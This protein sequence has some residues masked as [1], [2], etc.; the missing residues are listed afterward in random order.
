MEQSS[1]FSNNTDNA[2]ALV[3]EEPTLEQ[4]NT[5]KQQLESRCTKQ[6]LLKYAEALLP[7]L[8]QYPAIKRATRNGRVVN[9]TEVNA[10]LKSNS[11]KSTI[12][13]GVALIL[14]NDQNLKAYID[15]M[16]NELHE[17][18][19]ILLF[20]IFLTHTEA[21]LILK[22][23][24]DLLSQ[25][26]SNYYSGGGV[27]WKKRE[28]GFFTTAN[29]RASEKSKYGYRDYETFI[30][31]KK[32]IRDLFMPHFFPEACDSEASLNEL[33][34]GQWQTVNFEIE[35]Q[36]QYQLFAGLM[37]QD[38][39]PVKKKGI[40]ITDMKRAMKK[41]ALTEFF[42]D[43]QNEY[44]QNLHAYGYLQLLGLNSTYFIKKG[45][46]TTP[47]EQVVRTLIDNFSKLDYFVAGILYPHIKGLT[48]QMTEYGRETKLCLNML[49]CLRE[50][51]ERWLSIRDIYL[52]ICY[53]DSQENTSRYVA[54][55]FNPNDE[56]YTT[57]MINQYS[58]KIIAA[59]S[60]TMQFGYT[61][62]QMFA[63]QLA[64][65]GLAEV[66]LNEQPLADISP[67]SSLEYLRL[68]PL[69][70]YALGVTNDYEAPEQE[71]AAYFELDP[72]RLII[73]SL[74]DPNPYAQL[75][76][77]SST[78]ISHNRFET[79]ALSF[80]ANCTKREDV[81]HKISIFRRFIAKELP[82]LWEQFFQQLLQHCHPLKEDRTGYKR[83]ILSANNRD[84]IQLMTT[85]PVLR[86]IV[87]RAEGYR[88][89]VKN[90]DLKKFETQLKKHG[91][92]L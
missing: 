90:D 11:S 43:D 82:P 84:L 50:E 10:M 38:A 77:D 8:S 15:S 39:L 25:Q 21:K 74:V 35:S 75:L 36:T 71:Y 66:A 42:P 81:E 68:T 63:F 79:S 34:D 13:Q 60:Y 46:N 27:I 78:P 19:R 20:N 24:N 54:L 9:A 57:E 41:M 16:S 67:F 37:A 22:T 86:Q 58:N 31:L 85:D 83:Y 52:K 59:N 76:K 91:Y 53:L 30:T 92:L 72:E 3:L 29:Y 51:P 5:T 64:S 70:R 87:V 26:R 55:V 49:S 14:G 62:L 12:A 65:I 18:W 73:R 23:S 47:Y 88:I 7:W 28:Y 6:E 89:M 45:D 1:L 69:G 40:G 44:R 48:K 61:G 4:W 2:I 17:L 33:P 80:L 56:Q 32:S